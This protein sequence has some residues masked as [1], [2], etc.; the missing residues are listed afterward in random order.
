METLLLKERLEQ[1]KKENPKTRVR[2][3]ADSL[4]VSE[5]DLVHCAET[6]TMLRPDFESILKDVEKLG[7]VMALTRNDYAVHERKGIYS[8]TSFTGKIGLVANADI[9]LR[10][11]MFY[12]AHAFAVN[13]NGRK[14]LQFFDKWGQA[15][16]K[17]YITEDSNLSAYEELINIYKIDKKEALVIET[18]ILSKKEEIKDEEIDIEAFQK[19]WIEL[20]DTHEFFSMLTRFGVSRIQAMRLAPDT[21]THQLTV[22]SVE[23]LLHKVSETG[24]D[25]MVF[26]GNKSCIQIHTGK[27]NKIVRTGPWINILDEE[28]SM[29]LRDEQLT[30]VWLVKKPTNLGIIHSLEAYDKDGELIVQFF[31]KR[32][33]N[34][35][36]RDDWRKVVNSLIIS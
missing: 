36:E 7:K 9:D 30:S 32:K 2:E 8:E 19:S 31:G 28:F 13:E 21:Y 24:I 16:H 5:A 29:H 3:I 23:T 26:I 34:V 27:A 1:F 17:I 6:T 18:Q 14:S 15:I 35:P 12:W 22:N 10:L 11:F 25:F 20:Q 33:P 4:G